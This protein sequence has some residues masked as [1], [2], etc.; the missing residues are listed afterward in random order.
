MLSRPAKVVTM[1]GERGIG[2]VVDPIYTPHYFQPVTDSQQAM[3]MYNGGFM[4]NL[5]ALKIPQEDE[6]KAEKFRQKIDYLHPPPV[7]ARCKDQI[8]RLCPKE[9]ELPKK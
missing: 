4:F 3:K 1:K 9:P 6:V 2:K 7:G 8:T 5:L